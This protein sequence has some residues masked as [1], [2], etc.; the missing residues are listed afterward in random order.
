MT[1]VDG[2]FSNLPPCAQLHLAC[3]MVCFLPTRGASYMIA[4]LTGRLNEATVLDTIPARFLL[5]V[6][7][8]ICLVA[9]PFKLLIATL[10]G[11]DAV[12]HPQDPSAWANF[13]HAFGSSAIY[14]AMVP[15]GVVAACTPFRF[16]RHV[17]ITL[18]T[19]NNEQ[20]RNRLAPVIN[21]LRQMRINPQMTF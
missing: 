1:V 6:Q 14:A 19:R 21:I 11:L 20:L 2:F 5:I 8:I 13:V 16:V 4:D 15:A 9:L 7:S 17:L 18:N 10:L 3:D 12:Y